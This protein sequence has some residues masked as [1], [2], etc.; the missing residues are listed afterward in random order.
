M[1]EDKTVKYKKHEKVLVRYNSKGKWRQGRIGRI[2][3]TAKG[4]P[5]YAIEIFGK[6]KMINPK[7]LSDIGNPNSKYDIY[8]IVTRYLFRYWLTD[9]NIKKIVPTKIP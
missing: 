3:K 1:I 6:Y 9:K 5:Y 8:R 2:D 7:G 4:D